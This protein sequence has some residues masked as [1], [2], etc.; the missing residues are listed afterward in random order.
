MSP[1][2]SFRR[3]TSFAPLIFSGLLVLAT[4][5]GGCAKQTLPPAAREA[6]AKE[7][8]HRAD[9]FVRNIVEGKYSYAYLDF[10]YQEAMKNVDR[11]LTAYPD[12]ETAK[13]L[14]NG[15]LKLDKYPIGYFRNT[16][17]VQLGDMKEATESVV[18][19]A[20]Y[21]HN[22]PEANRQE[23]RGA[24]ALILE[25]LCR[26]VRSDEALIFP[27]LPED[28]ML[29]QSTI[30]RM[31]AQGDQQ[32]QAY[33][34]VQAADGGDR[35]VLAGAYGRGLAI[36]GGKA[37]ELDEFAAGFPSPD[38]QAEQGIFLGMVERESNGYRDTFDKIR[39]KREEDA[40]KAARAAGKEPEKL[41]EQAVHYD[42]AGYYRQKFGDHPSAAVISAY[43][44]FLALHGQWDEARTLASNAGP[45]AL[46]TAVTSY[47]EY[48]ALNEKFTGRETLHREMSL[49]P[50]DVARCE[51]KAV[52]LL[53][54]N[55]RYA[56][57]DT[58]KDA[59]I[60][61]FPRF[62]DQFIRSRMRG[63]FYGRTELFYLNAKTIP[64]LGIKDPAVC[65][66]VLLDWFLAPNKLLKG[67]SWGADQILF[68]YFSM[69]KEGRVVSRKL[70]K[71]K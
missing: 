68:K 22:L 8:Y 66:E 9:L 11:I 43:A 32:G 37:A 64:S 35:A 46:V 69:Q 70:N 63:V 49:A 52:E 56:E 27:V 10:Y 38:L 25:T 31:L 21:L 23:S 26:L 39:K 13:K 67:S 15:E 57:A 50:D 4:L 12:T 36:A 1:F 2:L 65:A 29:A 33:S 16:L 59:G 7:L 61:E 19:C 6:E 17:L 51:L 24:I 20:I 42:I 54:Q 41:K 60:A 44:G 3:P 5:L 18:N 71:V 34:L 53:A 62:H 47:Y 30:V 28:R 48:L 58:L 45:A 14:Q 40:L 55:A